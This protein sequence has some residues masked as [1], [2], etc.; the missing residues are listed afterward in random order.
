VDVRLA[1]GDASLRA[2]Y[3]EFVFGATRLTGRAFKTRA[4]QTQLWP[5]A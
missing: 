1:Y 4:R 5:G 2:S 3:K